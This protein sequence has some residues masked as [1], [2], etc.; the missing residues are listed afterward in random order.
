M[1]KMD[2]RS[3]KSL[4]GPPDLET[5]PY[6][7][8]SQSGREQDGAA[9]AEEALVDGEAGAGALHLAALGLAAELPGDLADLRDGLGRDGLAEARQPTR[10]V[11]RDAPAAGGV[12]VAQELLGLT[13]RSEEHTSELQSLMRILYAVFCLKK[14]KKK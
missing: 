7:P 1:P 5:R 6:G 3:W 4:D 14:K 8:D 12:A 10:R 13:G 11:A 9:V 2:F